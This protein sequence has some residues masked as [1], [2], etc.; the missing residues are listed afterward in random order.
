MTTS[1]NDS[2]DFALR[3]FEEF[4]TSFDADKDE[5]GEMDRR[6]GDGDFAVNLDS[7][8]K[9]TRRNLD[10]LEGPPSLRNVFAAASEAF[11]NTGGTS[12]PLLGMW[13]REFNKAAADDDAN[14]VSAIATGAREGAAAVQ[15]VGGAQPGDKT[16]V[17]AMAPAAESLARSAADGADLAAAMYAAAGAARKGADSTKAL[18]ARRGRAS[19]V[20]EAARGVTDPGAAAI[21][22]FFAAGHEAATATDLAD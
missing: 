1:V 19:Y 5:L 22:L 17:D 6:S 16:M 21:A 15:R 11:L 3:W 13:L 9:L 12:G 4:F 14:V 18:L 20:G 10:R 8:L 2:G 7:A